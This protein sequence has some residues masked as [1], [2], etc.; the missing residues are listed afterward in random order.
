MPRTIS[1]I[2]A[3]VL[4][5]VKIFWIYL[6]QLQSARIRGGQKRDQQNGEELLPGQAQRILGGEA[7]RR[8]DPGRRAKSPA[9]ARREI[10]QRPPP[11]PRSCPSGSPGKASSRRESPRAASR[12]RAGRRIA[13]RPWASSPPARRRKAPPQMV[14]TPVIDPGDQQAAR[15]ARL[16]RDIRRDDEDARA[17]HRADDDHGRIEQAQAA[18]EARSSLAAAAA[19]TA[20]ELPTMSRHGYTGLQIRRCPR[21]RAAAT[22][23]A[24][25]RN[26]RACARGI[27][28][29][30][31]DRAPR[32]AN[33]RRRGKCPRRVRA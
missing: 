25:F 21:F 3:S 10:A 14:R 26:A 5:E 23:A 32:P 28:A 13:R 30:T 12:I 17:D 27:V 4:A 6:P 15:R 8:D 22:R 1:A 7:H 16:P 18:D 9:R 24:S 19:G 29:T 20:E 2:S 31:I 11:P 33:R